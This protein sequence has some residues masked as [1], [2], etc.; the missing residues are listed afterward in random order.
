MIL[1]DCYRGA[2]F[3]I[4]IYGELPFNDLAQC[5]RIEVMVKSAS[6]DG[7][8]L[9]TFVYPHEE[10]FKDIT[11]TNTQL[12]IMLSGEDTAKA[13]EGPYKAVVICKLIQDNECVIVAGEVVNFI[14]Y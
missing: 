4:D 14:S 7:H 11:A 5:E 13:Y 6:K 12:S 8:V 1:A 9:A 3:P 2:S 10:G